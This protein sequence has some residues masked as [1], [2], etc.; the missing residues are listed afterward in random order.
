MRV[1]GNEEADDD[2]TRQKK[3]YVT[4]IGGGKVVT[5]EVVVERG[6]RVIALASNP[7]E[8]KAA[9]KSAE[10]HA[11]T[12]IGT[13]EN[14][15]QSKAG[16]SNSSGSSTAAK[17][18]STVP[19][20]LVDEEKSLDQL[21]V[22]AI[23]RESQ[24]SNTANGTT[25]YELGLN[26]DR[27]IG[28]ATAPVNNSA[29]DGSKGGAGP[30]KRTGLLEQA[31]IPGLAE[32]EGED[33]KFKHDLGHRA[34]DFGARSKSYVDVPVSEFGAALLRGMGWAGPQ[35]DDGSGGGGGASALGQNAEPRHHRLG[36]GAQP[37]PPEEVLRARA[38]RPSM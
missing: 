29:V 22:E 33:A 7:W 16:K 25:S 18:A 8:R 9:V 5:K 32:V 15:N 31:M 20:T 28:M 36:L 34:E 10:G 38:K 21:A 13:P 3:D 4:G 27:V 19:P 26:S 17:S 37:K 23:T 30:T 6:P 35:G 14:D 1:V 12:A 11:K 24:S 2:E